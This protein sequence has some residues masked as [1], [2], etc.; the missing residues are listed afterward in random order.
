MRLFN[1]S[2]TGPVRNML[3]DVAVLSAT[4]L[5]VPAFVAAIFGR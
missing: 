4:E 3:E 5:V 2:L 1:I